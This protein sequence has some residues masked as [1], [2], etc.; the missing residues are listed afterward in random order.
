MKFG[1]I[2][3]FIIGSLVYSNDRIL[4]NSGSSSLFTVSKDE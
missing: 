2:F 1:F 4:S 3:H